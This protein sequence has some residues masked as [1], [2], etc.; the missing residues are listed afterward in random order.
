GQAPRRSAG[1]GSFRGS[2]L[3]KR[4]TKTWYQ[5]ASAAHAGGPV[6]TGGAAG[7]AGALSGRR[8]WADRP[9]AASRVRTAATARIGVSFVLRS[10]R[11]QGRVR[12]GVRKG[13]VRRV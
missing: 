10:R 3:R 2:P 5:T 1:L 9:A 12:Q 7:A 8:L 11:A 4:S 6:R 13:K